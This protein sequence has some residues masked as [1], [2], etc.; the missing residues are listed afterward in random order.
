MPRTPNA[1]PPCPGRCLRIGAVALLL[2][3]L[4]AA[5]APAPGADA[6]AEGEYGP[7][8]DG[9]YYYWDGTDY[10]R[11]RCPQTDGSDYYYQPDGRGG[12]AYAMQCA[13]TPLFTACL[14]ATGLYAESY[15]DGS[16]YTEDRGRGYAI[17]HTDGTV[18]EAGYYDPAGLQR[19]TWTSVRVSNAQAMRNRS[20]NYWVTHG[21]TVAT[22]VRS[23][24]T[25][26]NWLVVGDQRANAYMNCLHGN[27]S[28][29]DFDGD[30]R[31]GFNELAEYCAG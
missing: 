22:V 31:T 30:R 28:G 27:D 26:F 4:G 14:F 12:W 11:R 1:L 23:N 13:A 2:A 18:N 15:A 25:A 16:L 19:P 5:L 8:A 9:C 10:V 20:L 6:A 7:K 17:F 3:V 29:T 24:P 21:L